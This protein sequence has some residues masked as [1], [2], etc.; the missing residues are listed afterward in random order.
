MQCES[1]AIGDL[2]VELLRYI[3][4]AFTDRRDRL[5]AFWVCRSWRRQIVL[6][7]RYCWTR[8]ATRRQPGAL[9][10]E[11]VDAI[12]TGRRQWAMWLIGALQFCAK[13]LHY[14][15]CLLGAVA[16]ADLFDAEWVVWLRD[17][18]CRWT[19]LSASLAIGRGCRAVLYEA[20]ADGVAGP[21]LWTAL[22][23]TGDVEGLA[24]AHAHQRHWNASDL[25]SIVYAAGLAGH[26]DVLD[27]LVEGLGY[28]ARDIAPLVFSHGH[29]TYPP[30]MPVIAW[31]SRVGA[32]PWDKEKR[33]RS[34]GAH[35]HAD[36]IKYA[37]DHGATQ[38]LPSAVDRAIFYGADRTVRVCLDAGIV[39]VRVAA[40][41]RCSSAGLSLS[42][43]SRLY[44]SGHIHL[45]TEA[46]LLA[47]DRG[48]VEM[49]DW[50]ASVDCT[51]DV[52]ILWRACVRESRFA[53]ALWMVSRFGDPPIGA[54]DWMLFDVDSAVTLVEHARTIELLASRG[55][56]WTSKACAHIIRVGLLDLLRRAAAS[57]DFVWEPEKWL[58]LALS[59]D[60]DRHR[61]MAR[62]IAQKTGQCVE[63][64]EADLIAAAL[65]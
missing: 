18:G 42:L 63:A 24:W 50:L 4:V 54:L 45:G 28:A 30:P 41:R 40:L 7:R 64:A 56:K 5:A 11:V 61:E 20:H 10:Q 52:D 57:S 9:F 13:D 60:S 2:P 47:I 39:P 21:A 44:A 14:R 53:V 29:W 1:P 49:L 19:S 34:A 26:V 25:H 38:W 36:I 33:M 37:L 32:L 58:R 15:N 17:R 3:L 27:W 65:P 22:A 35:D 6:G 31:A 46:C 62:W 48:D 8:E 55:C 43:V 16:G 23:E 12:R 59:I 51:A